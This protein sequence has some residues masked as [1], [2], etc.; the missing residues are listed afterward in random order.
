VKARSRFRLLLAVL[1]TVFIGLGCRHPLAPELAQLYLGD[2]LWG[3]LFFLLF[4]WLLPR[5]SSAK[6]GLGAAVTTEAIELSQLYQADWANRLRDTRLGGLLLGHYFLWSD[7]LCVGLGALLAAS[8]D[9]LVR[10]RP[11]AASV[12]CA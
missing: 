12:T 4:A 9:V 6:L 7:V 3:V 8:V 10:A 2:V 11:G 5:T 1:G